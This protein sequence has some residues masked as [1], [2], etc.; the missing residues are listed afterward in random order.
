[1]AY[2]SA[3]FPPSRGVRL[4]AASA[5]VRS[6][7]INSKLGGNASRS[8]DIMCILLNKY[9]Y[10]QEFVITQINYAQPTTGKDTC[11]DIVI[12]YILI[13]LCYTCMNY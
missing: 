8:Q 5:Y 11:D 1:M 2:L 9:M 13:Y 7:I 10:M 12:M 3:M 6:Q 4:H